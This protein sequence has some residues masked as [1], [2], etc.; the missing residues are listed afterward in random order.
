MCFQRLSDRYYGTDEILARQHL[1]SLQRFFTGTNVAI[2][3]LTSGTQAA[4]RGQILEAL[5]SGEINIIVGT[6]SL[7]QDD[8]AFL[9]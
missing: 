5:A 6:H 8:I 7:I 3:C 2:A 9:L 4:A 1:K